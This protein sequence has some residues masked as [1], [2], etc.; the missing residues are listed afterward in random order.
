MNTKIMWIIIILLIVA[1]IVTAITDHQKP[2]VDP[3][4]TTVIDVTPSPEPAPPPSPSPEVTPEPSPDINIQPDPTPSVII[5]EITEKEKSAIFEQKVQTFVANLTAED[6]DGQIE[7]KVEPINR[8]IMITYNLSD[9][10]VRD[11]AVALAN[12]PLLTYN[13][14]IADMIDQ[15]TIKEM[16]TEMYCE[17][18]IICLRNNEQ[19]FAAYDVIKGEECPSLIENVG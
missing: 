16:K 15:A 11:F 17:H 6:T 1:V 13:D 9:E 8:T 18:L 14:M 19:I 3:Q 12:D 7:V 10:D 4:P 2:V 5:V